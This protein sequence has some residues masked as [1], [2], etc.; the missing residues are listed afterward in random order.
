MVDL[1]L[2]VQRC[3]GML[4][5]PMVT[6]REHADPLPPW[7]TVAREH[8]APLI[9][10]S[11]LISTVLFWLMPPPLLAH[12]G[13]SFGPRELVMQFVLTVAIGLAAVV[14]TGA[15]VTVFSGMF[16]GLNSF[17]GGMVLAG[18]AMTPHYLAEALKPL[19]AIG[20]LLTVVGA[21]VSLV[22]I[23][24]GAPV[25]LRLPVENRGKHFAMTI[26]TLLLVGL[27]AGAMLAQ[28]LKLSVTGTPVP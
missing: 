18:L 6:L 19:P 13:I 28:V 26:M 11:A 2:F 20:F 8:V 10:G 15:V 14:I 23:Y 21:I 16:G 27:V 12:Q 4:Q 17:N 3:V 22:L 25:V 7:Q 24:K 1:S 5:H 9:I